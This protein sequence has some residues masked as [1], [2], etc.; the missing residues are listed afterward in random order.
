[1]TQFMQG[2]IF[3]WFILIFAVVNLVL[4]IKKVIQLFG[5]TDSSPKQAE[6]GINAILFW[7]SMSVVVGFYAHFLGLFFAM[8]AISQAGDVSPA[9]VAQGFGVSLIPVLFGLVV[10]LFSALVWFLFRW[11]LKKLT[12]GQGS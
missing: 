8:Q 9:I 3:M 1:M 4:T 12:G 6:S 11:R 2:G 10:F 5:G 7:G